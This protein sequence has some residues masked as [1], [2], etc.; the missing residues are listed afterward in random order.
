M[1][2]EQ[3]QKGKEILGSRKKIQKSMGPILFVLL[4]VVIVLMYIFLPTFQGFV[5]EFILAGLLIFVIGAPYSFLVIFLIAF[6]FLFFLLR[7]PTKPT[8]NGNITT[9]RKSFVSPVLIV[10]IAFFGLYS[11][12]GGDSSLLARLSI[13]IGL[14][15]LIIGSI[16]TMLNIKKHKGQIEHL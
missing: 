6:I 16:H 4:L 13:T 11:L 2:D 15:L 14:L 9:R 7:F 5:E 10:G 1:G 12:L 3:F 8:N